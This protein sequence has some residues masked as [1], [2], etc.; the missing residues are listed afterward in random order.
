MAIKASSLGF[1]IDLE[2]LG[3]SATIHPNSKTRDHRT[4]GF[5]RYK[6][7]CYLTVGISKPPTEYCNPSIAGD[8]APLPSGREC[9]ISLRLRLLFC[10]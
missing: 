1:T 7:S 10:G 9:I 8:L 6:V 5:L 2:I 4:G 3:D